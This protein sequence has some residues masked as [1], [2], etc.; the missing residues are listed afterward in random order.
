MIKTKLDEAG[1]GTFSVTF[2][3][4][5]SPKHNLCVV[6]DAGIRLKFRASPLRGAYGV[7]SKPD[8]IHIASV[9][10]KPPIHITIYHLHKSSYSEYAI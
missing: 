5:R 8:R 7:E 1:I 4:F 3:A 6:Y 10:P 9:H 2:S